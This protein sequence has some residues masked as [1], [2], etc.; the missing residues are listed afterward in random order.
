MQHLILFCLVIF[1][2]GGRAQSTAEVSYSAGYAF[3][4]VLDT[5]ERELHRPLDFVL[6]RNRAQSFFGTASGYL[7]DS[8][9]TDFEQRHGLT[10]ELEEQMSDREAERMDRVFDK[11]SADWQ[12]RL[13]VYIRVMKDF[14]SQRAKVKLPLLTAPPNHM[15]VS[16]A[17]RW[18]ILGD[19]ATIQG[20]ACQAAETY[21]GGRRYVAWFAPSIPIADGPYVFAGLPGLIVKVSDVKGWCNYR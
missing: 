14:S 2:A 16:I 7:N 5:T 20:L 17:H 18:Q 6:V 15:A 13:S 12:P 1:T 21:Y 3:T 9:I 8:L 4:S 19:T 10:P 11:E